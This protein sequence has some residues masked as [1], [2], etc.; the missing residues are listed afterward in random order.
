L[1]SFLVSTLARKE[2]SFGKLTNSFARSTSPIKARLRPKS[3][4]EDTFDT[5]EPSIWPGPGRIQDRGKGKT[6]SAWRDDEGHNEPARSLK[7][8]EPEYWRSH[9]IPATQAPFA[10]EPDVFGASSLPKTPMKSRDEPIP[11]VEVAGPVDLADEVSR[12]TSLANPRPLTNF[13]LATYVSAFTCNTLRLSRDS[14]DFQFADRF[15]YF[16]PE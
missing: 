11:S 16:D 14:E 12:N 15:D 6:S 1:R 8:E 3:L 7:F 9:P 5:D 13:P 4:A 2:K 10:I